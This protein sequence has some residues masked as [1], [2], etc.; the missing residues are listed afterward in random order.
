[1]LLLDTHAWVWSVEGDTTRIGR[2][3]R[4]LIDQ[5]AA[6]DQVRVSP[7]TVFEVMALCAAG[8]LGFLRSAE[9]WLDEALEL[10]GLRL[11]DLTV[12][13]AVDAGQIPRTA[14]ADPMDRL[15]VA[16]ARSLGAT[17]VTAD[18]RILTYASTTGRLRAVDASR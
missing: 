4:R 3:A 14:L 12:A 9:Q 16:T 13:V 7:A 18:E 5:A 15:L 1:M 10:P 2:K 17:F 11:A 8:R 6:R